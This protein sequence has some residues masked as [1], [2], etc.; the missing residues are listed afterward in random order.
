MSR[1]SLYLEEAVGYFQE[2][3]RSLSELHPLE[4]ASKPGEAAMFVSYNSQ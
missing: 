3:L 2:E 1:R 4:Q